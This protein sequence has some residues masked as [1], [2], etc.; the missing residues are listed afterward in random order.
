MN[1][2][3]RMAGESRRIP[4]R[5]L[6]PSVLLPADPNPFYEVWVEGAR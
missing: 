3:D 6:D 1:A 2:L 5:K 4:A